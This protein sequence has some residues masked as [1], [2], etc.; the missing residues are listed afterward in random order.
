M[1]WDWIDNINKKPEKFKFI[2]ILQFWVGYDRLTVFDWSFKAS[3]TEM[4]MLSFSLEQGIF[5]RGYINECKVWHV[6]KY[7]K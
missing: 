3:E 4:D 1:C 7:S 2:Q 6:N 5:L